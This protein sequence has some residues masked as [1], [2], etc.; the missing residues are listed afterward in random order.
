M[1][2]ATK[3]LPSSVPRLQFADIA[4]KAILPRKRCVLLNAS[5]KFINHRSH[6]RMNDLV[7]STLRFHMA[8]F[9]FL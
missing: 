2:D 3:P 9:E 4:G 1:G 8:A 6:A 5:A 7:F